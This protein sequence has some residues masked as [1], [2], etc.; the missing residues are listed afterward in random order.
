M[1]LEK[2]R[3]LNVIVDPENN[4]KNILIEYVGEKFDPE[5]QNVT[6]EMIIEAM[7]GEFPEFLLAI[8]EENWVRGYQ[9]ALEDADQG[10]KLYKDYLT[11][12]DP[13]TG[14]HHDETKPEVG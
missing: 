10:E 14:D 9:Q 12:H 6:L 4:L 7:A 13:E 2:N 8:A 11:M 5:D 3:T 1:D